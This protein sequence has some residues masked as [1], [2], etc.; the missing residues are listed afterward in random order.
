QSP[1]P[2]QPVGPAQ[3]AGPARPVD[4]PVVVTLGPLAPALDALAAHDGDAVVLGSGDPG[5]FGIVRALRER[6]L[7]CAVWPA[8]SSVALAFARARLPW[9]DAVVVSAPGRGGGRA[10]RLAAAAAGRRV[11][12]HHGRAHHRVLPSGGGRPRLDRPKR[13]AGPRRPARPGRDHDIGA[14]RFA[15]KS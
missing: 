2:A 11:P 13:G 10:G 8:V 6:G 15:P 14:N 4:G 9:D 1:D 7:D 12:G 3:P 5:F